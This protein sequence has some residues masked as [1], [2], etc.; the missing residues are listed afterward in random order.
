MSMQSI[1]ENK[2]LSRSTVF[3]TPLD[4]RPIRENG[5][6]LRPNLECNYIPLGQQLNIDYDFIR[7]FDVFFNACLIQDHKSRFLTP[8][9]LYW[10]FMR[11]CQRNNMP[12]P[13]ERTFLDWINKHHPIMSKTLKSARTGTNKVY[14]GIGL[15]DLTPVPIPRNKYRRK[16]GGEIVTP[17]DQIKLRNYLGLQSDQLNI[18]LNCPNV[19][20][21]M[22]TGN[23]STM[24]VR[25]TGNDLL[26]QINEYMI[27]P[28][29]LLNDDIRKWYLSLNYT[30]DSNEIDKK[31]KE[32]QFKWNAF[33]N[34]MT[35][36]YNG[37]YF[38]INRFVS[39]SFDQEI[40]FT[41]NKSNDFTAGVKESKITDFT[42]TE[43]LPE[44][45]TLSIESSLSESTISTYTS[46]DQNQSSIAFIT[47]YSD[48]SK[49]IHNKK[50]EKK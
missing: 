44:L 46:T 37:E 47:A 5:Q 12:Y 28:W 36:R 40:C 7:H 13:P 42:S 18:L 45:K 35:L 23:N 1:P 31:T 41:R 30:P 16:I 11:W 10:Y 32:S 21:K 3:N 25:K 48:E 8:V 4:H 26:H 15:K 24:D 39:N 6:Q 2:Q 29:N 14:V 17:G 38:E 27:V 20:L 34:S 19:Y 43:I 49:R 50:L 9:E 33:V 22:A